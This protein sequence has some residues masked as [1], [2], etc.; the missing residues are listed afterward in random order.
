MD[1]FFALNIL[2]INV[3]E[4]YQDTLQPGENGGLPE[5]LDGDG[6][7]IVT[8]TVIVYVMPIQV[9]IMTK[10]HKVTCGCETYVSSKY[11]HVSLLLW[12]KNDEKIQNKIGNESQ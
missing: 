5:V 8:D 3:S 10:H 2:Q 7:A 9:V 6:I 12:R 4:L 1:N 11:L